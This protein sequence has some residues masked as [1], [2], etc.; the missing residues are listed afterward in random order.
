MTLLSAGAG[1]KTYMVNEMKSISVK[2]KRLEKIIHRFNRVVIAFSGGVD[3][4]FLLHVA[5]SLLGRE[6]VI[7]CIVDSKIYPRREFLQAVA[8]ARKNKIRFRVF[9]INVLKKGWFRRNPVNRCYFCKKLIFAKLKRFMTSMKYDTVMDG[10]NFDD[11]FDIRYGSKAK[12]ELGVISPL[13]ISGLRK[14][15]IRI[16]SMK[17]HLDSYDKPSLACLASRFPTGKKITKELIMR[18]EKAEDVLRGMG[19]SQIRVRDHDG[20][21]RIEVY[22]REIPRFTSRD[23]VKKLSSK[24]KRLGFKHITLDLEGYRTVL[25]KQ[26]QKVLQS[27]K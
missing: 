22:D 7:A 23:I 26:K 17:A 1:S 4:T 18:V 10:S 20:L 24:F 3:S 25:K 9:E 16:L 2:T 13:E 21:A 11:K 5:V 12:R 6:N 14:E 15:E 27:F 19:F 8:F